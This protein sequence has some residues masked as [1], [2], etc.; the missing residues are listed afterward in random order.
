MP[1]KKGA[2][3]KTVSKNIKTEIASGKPQDQAVAIALSKK[4]ES[5]KGKKK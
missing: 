2:S 5:E 3:D 1:L 4:K